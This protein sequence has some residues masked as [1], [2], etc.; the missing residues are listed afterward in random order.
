MIYKA[1]YAQLLLIN[2]FSCGKSVKKNAD[3]Y[4]LHLAKKFVD[5]IWFIT[6]LLNNRHTSKIIILQ[7]SRYG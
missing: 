7:A 4:I 3:W 6:M 5:K 2:I 1:Y